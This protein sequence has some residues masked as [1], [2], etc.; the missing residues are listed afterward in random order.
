MNLHKNE[1]GTYRYFPCK[2][3]NKKGN[4]IFIHGFATNSLYHDGFIE[5][6]NKE[7]DYYTL[8]LPGHGFEKYKNKKISIDYLVN[9][10]VELINS[11]KLDSFYLIGHSMGGGIAVR[12][13][14]ILKQKVKAFVVVT[15]MNSHLSFLK[16]K[17]YFKFN[18]NNYLKTKKLINILYYDPIKT[19]SEENINDFINSELKYQLENR[20]FL[21]KLKN[22]MFSL[23]NLYLC[24]KNEKI[25]DIPMLSFAGKYDKII[26]K[27][28]VLKSFKNIE[29]N[30]YLL[31]K[32]SAHI[33]FQEEKELYNSIVLEFFT[34]IK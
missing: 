18:P 2:N 16:I 33:I 1:F 24:R 5:D 23:K 13:C 28:S 29:K 10:C 17:N 11:L 20:K 19:I 25:I 15:P 27:E 34:R 7:F 8:E 30:T 31:F 9:Y 12:V 14:N 6:A 22:K 4:I 3:N 32:K 26:N 21:L